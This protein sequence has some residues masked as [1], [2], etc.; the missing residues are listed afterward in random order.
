MLQI[1]ASLTDNSRFAI[2]DQHIFYSKGYSSGLGLY[3]KKYSRNVCNM[4]IFLGKLVLFAIV[5][6][7]YYGIRILQ[8]CNDLYYRLQ[9]YKLCHTVAKTFSP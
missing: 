6:S 2:Y 1:V 7:A 9:D 3:C 8:I 5:T 4:D